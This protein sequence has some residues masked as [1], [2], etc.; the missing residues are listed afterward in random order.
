MNRNSP[1]KSYFITSTDITKQYI[2]ISARQQLQQQQLQMQLYTE[3]QKELNL[4]KQELMDVM[5][6]Y[7]AQKITRIQTVDKLDNLQTLVRAV[8]T[9]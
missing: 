4:Y 1:L 5:K 7:I 2:G 3:E 6:E 9:A 8:T